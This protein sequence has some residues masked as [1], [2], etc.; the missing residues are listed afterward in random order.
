MKTKMELRIGII[1]A[2]ASSKLRD[3]ADFGNQ[4]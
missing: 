4:E 3:S 2:P 1:V